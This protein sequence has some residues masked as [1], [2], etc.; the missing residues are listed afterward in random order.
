MLV[1]TIIKKWA[2]SK[3]G[4][5]KTKSFYWFRQKNKLQKTK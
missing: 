1:E 2:E 3:I 4:G 5:Y